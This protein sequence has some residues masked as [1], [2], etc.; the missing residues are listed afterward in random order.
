MI[1][2]GLV[3]RGPMPAAGRESHT[4]TS[5]TND[6]VA[7]WQLPMPASAD[8]GGVSA[9]GRILWLSGRY[10]AVVYAIDTRTGH[11]RATIPVGDGPHGL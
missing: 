7:P 1:S 6:F 9:D 10:N 3:E 2:R 11:L 5:P 4:A 8:M